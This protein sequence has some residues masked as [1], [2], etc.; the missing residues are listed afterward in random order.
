MTLARTAAGAL[1]VTLAIGSAAAKR[2]P[3]RPPDDRAHFDDGTLEFDH[4]AGATVRP[5][6]DVSADHAVAVILPP[7]GPERGILATVMS[8]AI[9]VSDTELEVVAGE[10]RSARMRNRTSWGARSE[11]GPPP[12]AVR[13]GD[14]R[15]VRYHDIVGSALGVTEQI[16]TCGLLSSRLV[17]VVTSARLEQRDVAEQLAEALFSSLHVRRR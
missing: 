13:I 7:R 12:E 4:P 17:C 8:G 5:A 1:A 15:Y 2:G 16:M 14:R 9:K 10:W 6:S 11:G 3:V